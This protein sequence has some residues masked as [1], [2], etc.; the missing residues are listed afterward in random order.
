M[1]RSVLS[2]IGCL[3]LALFMMLS[4]GACSANGNTDGDKPVTKQD[5][6]KPVVVLVEDTEP[7]GTTGYLADVL[8]VFAKKYQE[9]GKGEVTVT[10]IARDQAGEETEC[11]IVMY[12]TS[13]WSGTSPYKLIEAQKV[14]DLAPLMEAD[15]SFSLSD[16][17]PK[18]LEAG[19][20]GDKQMLFPLVYTTGMIAGNKSTSTKSG[21]PTKEDLLNSDS[22]W[23]K[24]E[25]WKEASAP[26]TADISNLAKNMLQP[27]ATFVVGG[28]PVIKIADGEISVDQTY[29]TR[30]LACYCRYY[31]G[32]DL[33]GVMKSPAPPTTDSITGAAPGLIYYD[34]G[35]AQEYLTSQ[36]TNY[37]NDDEYF[38]GP[39]PY[40][41]ETAGKYAAGVLSALGISAKSFRQER[42]WAFLS[43]CLSSDDFFRSLQL[44]DYTYPVKLNLLREQ[45]STAITGLELLYGPAAVKKCGYT[46]ETLA[47]ELEDIGYAYFQDDCILNALKAAMT[48]K[49]MDA[50]TAA[51]NIK[52]NLESAGSDWFGVYR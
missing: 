37:R 35:G 44:Y 52:N 23:E 22:F 19:K 31:T 25:G 42:A 15:Q 9:E 46:A 40:T 6:G 51:V 27:S 14:V 38:C 30:P 41:Q 32:D 13:F 28:G 48:E 2:R 18:V 34:V 1:K 12:E 50:E 43:Y 29:F 11:D 4:L 8:E 5:D 20:V 3:M 7:S 10:R 47:K 26:F 33:T 39:I 16:Y 24:M 36:V 21:L 49:G 17:N 45:C